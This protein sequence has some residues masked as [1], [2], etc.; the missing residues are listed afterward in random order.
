[1]VPSLRLRA[2]RGPGPGPGGRGDPESVRGPG[3]RIGAV[4]TD[5][6]DHRD[7]RPLAHW[8]DQN[9]SRTCNAHRSAVL[10]G[11]LFSGSGGE[12]SCSRAFKFSPICH[13]CHGYFSGVS[14][15]PWRTLA[16]MGT[17]GAPDPCDDMPAREAAA[18]G[19]PAAGI[20]RYEAIAVRAGH[21]AIWAE[22]LA[23][24]MGRNTHRDARRW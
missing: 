1:L 3:G 22:G 14:L 11:V 5:G 19:R 16:H 17:S 20:E 24:P 21:P 12:V 10:S 2:I 18:A 7:M 15:T 6:M 23:G 8:Q 9:T 13:Q 4:L